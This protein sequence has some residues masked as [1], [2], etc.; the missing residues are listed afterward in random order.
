MGSSEEG[1]IVVRIVRMVGGLGMDTAFICG[2][3]R[4]VIWA[5]RMV[6]EGGSL[7]VGEGLEWGQVSGGLDFSRCNWEG[8][9]LL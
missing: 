3:A 1:V 4:N 8:S 9:V 2:G 7:D 5:M 6:C